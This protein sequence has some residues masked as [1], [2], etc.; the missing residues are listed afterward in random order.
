MVTPSVCTDIKYRQFLQLY[1]AGYSWIREITAR[2][3]TYYPLAEYNC[4]NNH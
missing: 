3:Y 2:S 1:L 4:Y